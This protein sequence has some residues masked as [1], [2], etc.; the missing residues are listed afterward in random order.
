MID[1]QQE[2]KQHPNHLREAKTQPAVTTILHHN[3]C[4]TALPDNQLQP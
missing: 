2:Q 3:L 1:D 4:E